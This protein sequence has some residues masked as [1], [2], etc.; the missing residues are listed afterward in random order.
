MK[1]LLRKF[2]IVF[3]ILAG[4]SFGFVG[5]A[6]DSDQTEDQYVTDINYT[7][8]QPLSSIT[9]ITNLGQYINLVYR[10]ALGLVGII[11]TVLIMAGG[12]MWLTSAG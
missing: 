5:Q 3:V 8:E 2:L 1:F 6:A 11:A 9:T 7:L 4:L 12:V 10:Y